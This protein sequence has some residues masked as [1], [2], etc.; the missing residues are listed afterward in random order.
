MIILGKS[1]SP[2]SPSGTHPK[3]QQPNSKKII[4][5]ETK[6][7]TKLHRFHIESTTQSSQVQ[8]EDT[9]LEVDQ[10]SQRAQ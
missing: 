4:F 1:K 8:T 7:Q 5:I 2:P 9:Q 6:C 10:C 3:P